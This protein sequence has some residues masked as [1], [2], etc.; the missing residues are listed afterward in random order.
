MLNIISMVTEKIT[1]EYTKKK[2][3]RNFN[4]SLKKLAKHKRR[5]MQ[6]LR[7]KNT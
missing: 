3:K 4:I 7:H 1:I 2:I 5:Q 6:Q